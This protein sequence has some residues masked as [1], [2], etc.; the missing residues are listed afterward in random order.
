MRTREW[1]AAAAALLLAACSGGR[2]REA[3]K[4][5]EDAV[6]AKLGGRSYELDAANYTAQSEGENVDTVH[7]ASD[8]V[9]DKSRPNE[10]RQTLDCRVRFEPGKPPVVI[11]LGFDWRAK[12]A[13]KN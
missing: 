13:K 9:F 1:L 6:R 7:L 5:C 3:T 11:S 10:Y 12:D 4:A 8:I 2:E